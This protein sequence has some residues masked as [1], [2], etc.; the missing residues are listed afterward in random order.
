MNTF[1]PPPPPPSPPPPPPSHPPPSPPPPPDD[2]PPPVS[3]RSPKPRAKRKSDHNLPNFSPT[4]TECG[5]RFSS[6]KALFGHMRC[7]PER[8]WRGIKPPPHCRR[9]HF[10]DEDFEVADILL[11]LANGPPPPTA[12][13][14]QPSSGFCFHVG[15]QKGEGRARKRRAREV[16]ADHD[17][18]QLP[19][20]H[21]FDLNLPPPAESN[22][23]EDHSPAL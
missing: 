22:E 5:R 9:S 8:Q 12:A 10:T 17:R 3:P 19:S 20:L 7:H 16:G 13:D 2:H 1:N 18:R 14:P 4:C 15:V 11:L 6:S 21:L 23:E